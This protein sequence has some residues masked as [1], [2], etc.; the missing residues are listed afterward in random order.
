MAKGYWLSTG[1]IKYGE[2]MQHYL[3]TIHDW[4]PSVNWELFAR[5]LAAIEKESTPGH[6]A[7]IIEFPSKEDEVSGYE[8][9]EY[10]KMI[11]L[12]IPYSN[13]THIIFR[14]CLIIN[15]ILI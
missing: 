8:S 4:L 14:G 6:L 1:S 2:G 5:D 12:R 10:Q 7:V 13:L 11:Q 3:K 9:E 15:F